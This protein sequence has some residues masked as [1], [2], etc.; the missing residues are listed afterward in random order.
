MI[1]SNHAQD[2]GMLAIDT[3]SDEYSI[4]DLARATGVPSRTIR[5]YQSKGALMKPHIRGRKAVY[6]PEHVERLTLI[7]TLQDRGLRIKAIRDLVARIEAGE[8]ELGEWLGL[9]A[10][11]TAP[12]A[13]DDP[14]LLSEA[15]L[16]DLI[17]ERRAG[18]VA[19][20]VRAEFLER[21][22]ASY[23]VTS[24]ALL[25]VALQM[26]DAGI[27]PSAT[28][29]AV[30]LSRKHMARLADDLSSHFAGLVG[31]GFGASG[32]A[33]DLSQAFSAV[34][35]LGAEMVRRVFRQELARVLA[36]LVESGRASKL[37]V[38]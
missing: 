10:N 33:A 5:F 17:G 27:D 4:D 20:L 32:S 15:E 38:R 23:F 36:D 28:R 7:G 29:G 8:L 31:D 11:L 9:E 26:A 37:G 2:A 13:D 18:F 22:G 34:R 16:H 21:K 14:V 1:E 24:P 3:P 6:G 30:A 35:P 19:H 25:A 12:S